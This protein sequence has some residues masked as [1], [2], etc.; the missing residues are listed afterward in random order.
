ME[1]HVKIKWLKQID[2]PSLKKELILSPAD[3]SDTMQQMNLGGNQTSKLLSQP[4]TKQLADKM[5]VT[6][7]NN[8]NSKEIN[9]LFHLECLS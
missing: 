6:N 7:S 4:I 8:S 5:K 9:I 2:G 3:Q 1:K